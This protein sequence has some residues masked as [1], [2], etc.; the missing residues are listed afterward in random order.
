MTQLLTAPRAFTVACTRID[1][2]ELADWAQ[3][4]GLG[5][6][7]SQ[8]DANSPLSRIINDLGDDPDRLVEFG[9]RHCYRSW[10]SGRTR[11]EYIENLLEMQH[12]SVFEHS[13]ISYAIQGVSRSLTHELVR[14]RP[15]V[16][17]SQES[18]RYVPANE[19]NFVVP[20]LLLD[21]AHGD[22]MDSII[23]DFSDDCL[24]AL[25]SYADMLERIKK[26][27][28][29]AQE[30]GETKE[31]TLQ[32]KRALEAARSLLPNASETRLLWTVN[33]RSLRHVLLMRGGEPADLEIRRLAVHL[34][35][36]TRET[37]GSRVI[38]DLRA[39]TGSF[40]VE[41]LASNR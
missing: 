41:V 3:F 23:Q 40:G 21:L 1:D 30:S 33:L 34:F 35:E 25:E 9:G 28:G 17:I 36:V 26:R 18:Q 20:P 32:R 39:Y 5:A 7:A 14:H 27:F 19:I 13:S 29:L 15:G 6:H 12:G 22:L 10:E 31:Q 16:A 4:N 38:A 11:D 37:P 2:A 24:R 8:V